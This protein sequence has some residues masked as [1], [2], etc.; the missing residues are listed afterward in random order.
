M[1]T[2]AEREQAARV[3]ANLP[4]RSV[5]IVDGLALGALPDEIERGRV[6]A[7]RRRARASSAGARDRAARCAEAHA[8]SRA[9]GARWR[10]CGASSSRAMRRSARWPTTTCLRRRSVS[11]SPAPIRR[12]SRTVRAARHGAAAVRRDVDRAQ[13]PRSA[14]SGAGGRAGSATG[15]CAVSAASATP[16]VGR[17][18]RDL[19]RQLGLTEHVTFEGEADA[20]AIARHYDGADVFVL[21]TLYEG[22]G[23]AVAEALARGLPIVSTTTG[24]IPEIVPEPRGRARAAGRRERPDRRSRLGAA[25]IRRGAA[26]WQR[27]PAAR[28]PGCRRGRW[29]PRRWASILESVVNG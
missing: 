26:A 1:P 28:A 2:A 16:I 23:M 21:P 7:A 10:S 19:V 5:V 18:L 3:L 29:R 15:G 11:S 4:P 14:V 22:Y 12:R 24:A 25:A 27:A 8:P 6:E 17:R 20:A 9:S 13:G